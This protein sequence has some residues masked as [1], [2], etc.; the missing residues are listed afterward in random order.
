[1]PYSNFVSDYAK[2][3]RILLIKYFTM[4]NTCKEQSY[5]KKLKYNL[6]TNKNIH[7]IHKLKNIYYI[8]VIGFGE[9]TYTHQPAHW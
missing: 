6:D 4:T 1:M 2:W 3:L 9:A 5:C 8:H 7:N